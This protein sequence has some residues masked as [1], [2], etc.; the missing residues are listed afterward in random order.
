[1]Y[2]FCRLV[3]TYTFAKVEM[4]DDNNMTS[5]ELTFSSYN[6]H[7]LPKKDLSYINHLETL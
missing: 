1:M 6:T 4:G 5:L 7:V 2:I 3:S